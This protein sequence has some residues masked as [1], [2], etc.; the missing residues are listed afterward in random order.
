MISPVMGTPAGPEWKQFLHL[1]EELV[2]QPTADEQCRVIRAIVEE[3]TRSRVDV[4]LVHPFYPLPGE[5]NPKVLPSDHAPDLVQRAFA[6]REPCC[7]EGSAFS[8]DCG[9][10]EQGPRQVAFPVI[11]QG[12][13]LAVLSLER[14]GVISPVRAPSGE[15]APYIRIRH[16]R[17]P[18]CKGPSAV[19]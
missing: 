16:R 3:M 14:G 15:N 4:W 8:D 7:P 17:H 6:T 5:T 19:F 11:T 9:C 18:G 1:A 12:F 10:E 13:M 2:R